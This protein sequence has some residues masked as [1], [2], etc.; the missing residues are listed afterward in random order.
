MGLHGVT[1]EQYD[2]LFKLIYILCV[3]DHGV[4]TDEIMKALPSIEEMLP[5]V[6]AGLPH[7]FVHMIISA[8]NLHLLAAE[9]CE[10]LGQ[11]ERGLVY[12]EHVITCRDI[13]KG[14]STLPIVQYVH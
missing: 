6:K 10:K 7:S 3:S 4:S 14:G 1:A 11:Y 9:V 12:A 13:T 5:M 8:L 2:W